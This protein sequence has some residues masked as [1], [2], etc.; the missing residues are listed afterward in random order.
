MSNLFDQ[1]TGHKLLPTVLGLVG[2][3]IALTYSPTPPG[4]RLWFASVLSGA[5]LAFVGTPIVAAAARHYVGLDWLPGD[6]SVDGLIGLMLGVTGMQ[7]VAGTI[8]FA[9]SFARDPV[10]TVFAIWTR[11]RGIKS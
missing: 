4:R 1:I 10:G 3:A 6:G 9:S 7:I 11:F 5:V 8:L 2:A